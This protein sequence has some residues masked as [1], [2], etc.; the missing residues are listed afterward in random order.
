[1]RPN[2]R[3]RRD[4]LEWTDL[5]DRVDLATVATAMLGPAL[6][7]AAGRL[8]WICP[9]HDDH[10]PSLQV[11]PR[12]RIWKCWPCNL[13]GDAPALVMKLQRISFPEALAVIADVCGVVVPDIRPARP[14]KPR[15]AEAPSEPV[16]S[17]GVTERIH[18]GLPEELARA[19]VEES[20][21]RLWTPEG[22]PGLEHLRGRG[23]ADPTIRRQHLGWAGPTPIPTADGQRRVSVS[24]VVIPWFDGDRLARVKIRQ[25]DGSHL[26]YV[27]AFE[28]R[29]V[30]YPGLELIRLG[31][32]LIA[33]E[34]ELDALLLGQDLAGLAGVVTI[35]GSSARP[36]SLTLATINGCHPLYAAHDA[37]E[38]GDRAADAPWLKRAIRVRPPAGK[39][40][41][42]ARAAGIDL[43]TWWTQQ[44][45]LDAG[46]DDYD[47]EE[48]AAIAEFDGGLTRSAA[49]RAAGLPGA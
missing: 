19:L 28:D 11:D 3:P 47:R 14:A 17:T 49:E 12:R 45:G 21:A 33:V 27:Q 37:D 20:A 39:D 48:R 31:A 34:G 22:R 6:K 16:S 26:R 23:L 32:P 5:K 4:R 43:R 24:G 38:A 13:G 29:P 42:E 10:D 1:M 7:Q 41:T 18:G 30:V 44:P 36:D 8:Y 9:F 46:D 40:W 35:G 2:S 25:P 15:K